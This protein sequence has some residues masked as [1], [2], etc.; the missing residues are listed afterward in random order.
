MSRTIDSRVVEMRFDNKQF[1][2]AT[3]ETLGTLQ[4]LKEALKLTDSKKSLEGLDKSI[5]DIRLDGIASGVAA[6]EKRFST[7]GIIG[8]QVIK[9]ITNALQN[10]LA[11][12][13]HSVTDSIVSGGI[14]RAMNLENAHFQLQQILDTEE[15]VQQVM[16]AANDSVDGTAYS[17]D[18]AAKAASQ[19]TAS[20]ITDIGQLSEALRGMAGVTATY[21]ADYEQMS[22][23]F[24]Q[25]AGQGRLM[26]DQLLQ[27]STRGANAAATIKDYFNG[28]NSGAIQAN[29]SVTQ[30]IKAVSNGAQVGE[31]EIRDFVSKGKINFEVFAAAMS[32]TF[33]DSAKKA[34]DTFNG[35]LANI[36]AAL[37]RI[38]A[39][40]ISPLVEQNSKIVDLFNTVRL[41]IN[42]VK[43]A[44]VFDEQLGNINALSKQVTDTIL[45]L[46]SGLQ[47]Y[48]EKLDITK[49]MQ[50]FYYWVEIGK[51]SAKNLVSVLKP[52]A[53]AFKEVFLN[54]KIDDVIKF[55]DSLL[56]F[57]KTLKLSEKG[58]KDLTDAFK[59]IFN[60]GKLL[61]D[62]FVGLLKTIIPINKPI[63]TLTEGL[64]GIAGA[65]GRSLT[66]FTDWLRQ[67]STI[68][69]AY[70]ILS[71]SVQAV[72][73]IIG[74]AAD[75]VKGFID[76]ASELDVVGT[77]LETI[78]TL[79]GKLGELASP[80]LES[81]SDL[82]KKTGEGISSMI[83]KSSTD[84]LEV[85]TNM[86][87]NLNDRLKDFDLTKPIDLIGKFSDSIDGLVQSFKGSSGLNTFMDNFLDFFKKLK[88]ALSIENALD[89]IE[90]IKETIGG[91]A[92]WIKETLVPMFS[93]VSIGGVA[94]GAGGIGF[95][96]AILKVA[97][98]F[99]AAAGS[100]KSI[101]DTFKALKG[102]L[103]AYQKELEA[104]RLLTVAKAIGILALAIAGL[105][106]LD[107]NKVLAAATGLSMVAGVLL[108]ATT[109]LMKVLNAGKKTSTL[110]DAINTFAS[111]LATAMKNL[112]KALVIK[113]IGKAVKNFGETMLMIAVSLIGIALM[114]KNDKESLNAALGIVEG[115]AAVIIGV[116]AVMTSMGTYLDKGASTFK[117][118]SVAVKN[119][120][121]SL[122]IVV[123]SLSSLFK[124]EL[125]SDYG[126]KL[127]ILTGIIG[128]LTVVSLALAKGGKDYGEAS[129]AT[130]P[131][132]AMSAALFLVVQSMKSLMKME[133]SDD[134]EIK[135][136]ILGGIFGILSVIARGMAETGKEAGGAIKAAGTILAMC[137][138]VGTVTVSLAVLQLIK[139]DDLLKGAVALGGVL[140]AL[141]EAIKGAAGVAD[142]GAAKTVLAMAIEIAA[143]TAAL[144]VLSMIPLTS[145]AKAAVAL[146]G[147]LYT[148]AK[149]LD[150]ASKAYSPYNS[151]AIAGMIAATAAIAYE[152][153]Q[154]AQQPWEGMLAAGGAMSATLLAFGGAMKI[155]STITVDL[156][157]IGAVLG[158]VV[159]LIPIALAL[160][161]LSEQPWENMLASAAA[162]SAVMLS[163]SAAL[164]IC[165]AVGAAVPAALAGILAFDAFLVNFIAILGILGAISETYSGFAGTMS[166]G[167]NILIQIGEA[168]GA[169]VGAIIKG[170]SDQI[171]QILPTLGS[172]LSDFS[173]NVQSFVSG[174]KNIDQTTVDGCLNLVKMVLAITAAQ[175]LQGIT[176]FVTGGNTLSKFGSQ[177]LTFGPQLLA[178][179][180]IVKNVDQAAVLG[181][182][183]AGTM[184]VQ[185]ANDLPKTGGLVSFFTGSKSLTK[186]GAGLVAFGVE[187]VAFAKIVEDVNPLAVM[188]AAT[189]GQM[190][191]NLQNTLPK[192]GGLVD[193]FSGKQSL[194]DFG[195]KLV[196]FGKAMS[197]YADSVSGINTSQ[198]NGVANEL[199]NLINV[200]SMIGSLDTSPMSKF[201]KGLKDMANNA[202]NE[203]ITAFQNGGEKVSTTIKNTIKTWE[204]SVSN[205]EVD[206][207][208]QSEKSTKNIFD[209]IAKTM[210]QEAQKGQASMK[211]HGKLYVTGLSEGIEKN[212][213]LAINAGK[214][215]A[216]ALDDGYKTAVQEHSPP[217][218]AI[219]HGIL[220]DQGV[221]IGTEKKKTDVFN[222]G[223]MIGDTLTSGLQANLDL[224]SVYDVYGGLG[225]E[226]VEQLTQTNDKIEAV[227]NKSEKSLKRRVDSQRRGNS[228][229]KAATKE[230]V[231]I[232]QDYWSQLLAVKQQGAEAE[233]YQSMSVDD[234]RKDILEGAKEAL[235]SYTESLESTRDSIMGQMDLFSEVEEKE[236]KTKEELI[237][238]LN[239]QIDAYQVYV[240]TLGELN[241]RLGDTKLGEYLRQL[242]VDSLGEL[243]AINSMTD[244]ELSNYAALYDEKLAL[245]TDAA[246]I[247][248]T[249][250]REETEAKLAEL[251]GG[252]SSAINLM[253]FSAMFDGSFESI[254]KYVN[255]IMIPLQDAQ[256]EA[257]NATK[258]ITQ[259]IASGLADESVLSGAGDNLGAQLDALIAHVKETTGENAGEAGKEIGGNVNTGI[260]EGLTADTASLTDKSNELMNLLENALKDAGEIHSP[261]AR[262]NRE[263]GLPWLQGIIEGMTSNTSLIDEGV[264]T[265]MSY[266][267]GQFDAHL[268]DVKT[269]STS[270]MQTMQS[271]IQNEGENFQ[272]KGSET[273]KS[274]L[275][276][277]S[278]REDVTISTTT[279][280]I[281]T[282]ID[283]LKNRLIDYHTK[284]TESVE[285]YLSGISSLFTR[286]F[287][288][289][290]NLL[291]EVTK[292]ID[293]VRH[294]IVTA[295]ENA[296]LGFV[297]GMRSKISEAASAA[298]ELA[299]SVYESAMS[300]LD[301][302]S[303]SKKMFNVGDNAG[304]GFVNGILVN[305]LN[306]AKAG[307]KLGEVSED[308]VNDAAS[309][310]SKVINDFDVFEE[311]VIRPIVDLTN[312]RNAADDI[313][314]MFNNAIRNTNL[315]AMAT[316]GVMNSRIQRPGTQTDQ[317]S[318]GE[319]KEINRFTFEQNNYSPKALSRTE[320]YRQTKNQFTALKGV[321]DKR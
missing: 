246:S 280:W 100:F 48:I 229:M 18:V 299:R 122:G 295:G 262:S 87:K 117:K 29:E 130:K 272:T 114:Y 236:S 276:G 121:L 86:I 46:A 7:M 22:M 137:A 85:F 216:K 291:S 298:A 226:L 101:P 320:I 248:L 199:R 43:K 227:N 93:D 55:S 297:E 225:D 49:P 200:S 12:G 56:K 6:L 60:V 31:A 177:L 238:N 45:N 51:T 258:A 215:L 224:N 213:N 268:E 77:V 53:V 168:I 16:Q 260:A 155:L 311:P 220:Y 17:F 281:N 270:I 289:G 275:Q 179:S 219:A 37:A 318:D 305:V 47:Q 181:A 20:G 59:G 173:N 232:E 11:K 206:L 66:S 254:N 80:I 116:V 193:M 264:S 214:K 84:G 30:T 89:K 145:L 144:G 249:G 58:S 302:H 159:A 147:V 286:A 38:G 109:E 151:A 261:S 186:F 204:K 124:M 271:V 146:G 4:R 259:A 107:S 205:G 138:F 105:S 251:F 223:K 317:S 14:K 176:S 99:E 10:T 241:E 309:D 316:S 218:V 135:F 26:G 39:G 233:K 79:F 182:A 310:F 72:I 76:R 111:G 285:N 296:T 313:V 78:T 170:F 104:Q 283:I 21:N 190:M 211:K 148:V 171:L 63:G 184:L 35:A 133:L 98:S 221:V 201:A 212:L 307:K 44:L 202:L 198:L 131:L 180:L 8:M 265:V 106:L 314:A 301:E 274:F 127:A 239:A 68:A 257:E 71:S 293:E 75:A 172:S 194:A 282:I 112:T 5:R 269:T 156:N 25:V 319:V 15:R 300:E 207:K 57:I 123:F 92:S 69:K 266:L 81:I 277:V 288:T 2:A 158:G 73:G 167:G 96:Y 245:A 102:V 175:F 103:V 160:Y 91:F 306:A 169:F 52:V 40:F 113:S 140:L 256:I 292:G 61:I 253:D 41:K 273:V 290:S 154:L 255:D 174:M 217:A 62:I 303:P 125:P 197:D 94:A 187:I 139:W 315:E 183:A 163:M 208:K 250:M 142:K 195:K 42:D 24:T 119:L 278:D 247:Q 252:M 134:W 54:F 150:S 82:V 152:L 209:A 23:I 178:F 231:Q 19:F 110:E 196:E 120:A 65:V 240:E 243:Q 1:Q 185:L 70:D 126:V 161:K 279:T 242:G 244:D 157:L 304:I 164:A 33:G 34:N 90:K 192:T 128:G 108:I 83:P 267:T 97:K 13:I 153:Y 188:G 234:F 228:S 88:D 136:M 115:I 36:K 129:V 9:N 3:K 294:L 64:I 203:F 284:G 308:A 74:N 162:I 27:L 95:I 28:V 50:L 165:S 191:I 321:L 118:V 237:D 189:I 149:A 312:V 230:S 235:Q 132:L 143:I 263:I 141:G 222:A 67:S 32:Y 210:D 166:A 287:E